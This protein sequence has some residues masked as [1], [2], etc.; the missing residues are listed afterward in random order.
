MFHIFNLNAHITA[1]RRWTTSAGGSMSFDAMTYRASVTLGEQSV[2]L[3]PKFSFRTQSDT[4][5]YTNGLTEQA[6]NGF[7]GWLPY[8]VKRWPVSTDKI[9][10]KRYCETNQLRV[11]PA[12][13]PQE[14]ARLTDFIVKRRSGSFGENI[15]GPFRADQGGTVADLRDSDY[16]EA[17]ILGR[18]CKIWYWNAEPVAMEALE[19]PYLIGDG[20][21]TL[22]ALASERRASFDRSHTLE[23]S[24]G[25][26]A[27]QGWTADDIVPA[28]ER[29][30]LDFKF[31][32]PYDVWQLKDRDCLESQSATLKS[33]LH[34][35]GEVLWHGI[36]EGIKNNSV[37]T[38]DAILDAE[39]RIWLL[40]MNS[41]PM[42]HQNCYGPMLDSIFHRE[43]NVVEPMKSALTT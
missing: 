36:P 22:S 21:R 43:S 32:T 12:W 40:E 27:W 7:A 33:Y 41:N 6:A 4:L 24:S 9:V 29:V 17:F 37:F 3:I 42:V 2:T 14:P 1:V 26:L 39:D 8:A 35:V 16:C 28:G 31:T 34:R 11:T 30:Y 15:L 38:V 20:R 10:F 25:M 5:A 23:T 19:L 13:R 18:T